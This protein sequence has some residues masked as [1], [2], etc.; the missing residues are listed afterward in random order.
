MN[1]A[2]RLLFLNIHISVHV[3]GF[4]F[5][6]NPSWRNKSISRLCN[7]GNLAEIDSCAESFFE[8]KFYFYFY[9]FAKPRTCE[10]NDFKPV[11][12][13]SLLR[14]VSSW[15]WASLVFLDFLFFFKLYV[16]FKLRW[17]SDK[18]GFFSLPIKCKLLLWSFCVFLSDLKEE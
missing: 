13:L 3:T 5:S 11:I 18:V 15:L 17:P 2:L 1:P 8:T 12:F 14:F 7:V 16:N 4:F 10:L 6:S 9:F